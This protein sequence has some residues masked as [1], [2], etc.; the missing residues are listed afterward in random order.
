MKSST[1]KPIVSIIIVN[2]K[3]E[4]FIKKCI[5]SIYKENERGF[6][7]IVVD[8]N[9]KDRSIE[10]VRRLQT[11]HQNLFLKENKIN[12]GAAASRNIGVHHSKGKYLLFLDYDT[13]IKK[14]WYSSLIDFFKVY[15]KAGAGQAKLLKMGTKYY[16]YAGDL[17]TQFG[18]LFERSRGKIDKGQF[19]QFDTIF[20]MKGA[21]MMVRKDV[22]TEIGGFDEDYYYLWEEP[23]LT[24]RVWLA[25]Y[26]VYFVPTLTVWHHYVTEGKSEEYYKKID[27]IYRGVKNGVTTLI[28]NYGTRKLLVIVPVHILCLICL[29]ILFLARLEIKKGSDIIRA[30]FW[31]I[32]YLPKILVKRKLIQ[33]SRTISDKK[34][35]NLISVDESSLYFIKKAFS[36]TL[37]I[38]FK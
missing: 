7:V 5:D 15:P 8:D 33:D 27:V 3:G 24:W 28:K 4:R 10:I 32:I 29:S 26:N 35:F 22:F 13:E 6:E 34:L 23:D 1:L 25:G 30:I 38:P 37:G 19:D 11:K 9:S 31:N 17:L 36:Y 16:D 12:R 18:F 14:S 2:Y 21:A 20:S